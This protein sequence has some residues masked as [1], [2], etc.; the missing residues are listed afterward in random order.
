MNDQAAE[1][2]NNRALHGKTWRVL[3][4]FS[5]IFHK[6]SAVL[7]LLIIVSVWYQIF[8]RI[9]HMSVHGMVEIGGYLLVWINFFAIAYTLRQKR[10]IRVDL[11]VRLMPKK[12]KI[13]F[14]VVSN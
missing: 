7:L 9:I 4:K 14:L 13:L 2:A 1:D 11:L 8:G 10:H 6:M 5:E 3:D 12:I